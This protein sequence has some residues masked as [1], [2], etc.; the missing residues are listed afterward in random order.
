MKEYKGYFAD[1]YFSETIV[2]QSELRYFNVRARSWK[3][4]SR[5]IV[6]EF[7][8]RFFPTEATCIRELGCKL[9]I[10]ESEQGSVFIYNGRREKCFKITGY[11]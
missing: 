5:L 11:R 2:Q 8:N 6:T 7:Y 3:E 4:A 10:E 9:N 1:D